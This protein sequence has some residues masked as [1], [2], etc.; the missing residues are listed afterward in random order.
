MS[1]LIW[2]VLLSSIIACILF[3]IS[4]KRPDYEAVGLSGIYIACSAAFAFVD[5]YALHSRADIAL[6]ALL[7]LLLALPLAV[8]IMRL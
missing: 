7:A 3:S 4:K 5:V 2:L 1:T 6:I 8:R